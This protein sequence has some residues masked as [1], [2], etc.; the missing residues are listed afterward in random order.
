MYLTTETYYRPRLFPSYEQ[1]ISSGHTFSGTDTHSTERLRSRLCQEVGPGCQTVV[2][3]LQYCV[4]GERER[5]MVFGVIVDTDT[6]VQAATSLITE[7]NSSTLGGAASAS[8]SLHLLAVSGLSTPKK[9][10]RNKQTR[11][12]EILKAF[13]K[14]VWH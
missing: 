10:S 7:I 5:T 8:R 9:N 4:T 13:V 1:T 11:I 14:S 6:C 12:S 3:S 2:R